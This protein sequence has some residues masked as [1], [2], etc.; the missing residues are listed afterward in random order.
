M[1]DP[2]GDL[3]KRVSTPQLRSLHQLNGTSTVASRH[4]EHNV[5][6]ID[7]FLTDLLVQDQDST[8]I[9]IAYGC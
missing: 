5:Q 3:M 1:N 8:S 6:L 9:S 2:I 7:S 4:E